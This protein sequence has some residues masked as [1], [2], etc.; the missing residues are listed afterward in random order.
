MAG[1]RVC[2]LLMGTATE[3]AARIAS[4]CARPSRTASLSWGNQAVEFTV[5][6]GVAPLRDCDLARRDSKRRCGALS[7]PRPGGA[8]SAA[9]EGDTARTEWR[10]G[11]PASHSSA[12]RLGS[13]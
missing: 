2:A 8:I 3:E 7:A 1:E 5:S 13:A 11:G 12:S 4:G 10:D 6:I 9:G